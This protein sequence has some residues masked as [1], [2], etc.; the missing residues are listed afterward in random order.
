MEDM[1]EEDERAVSN[2]ELAELR[3]GLPKQGEELRPLKDLK[4]EVGTRSG[5]G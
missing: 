4:V 2:P 3:P 5:G 1:E